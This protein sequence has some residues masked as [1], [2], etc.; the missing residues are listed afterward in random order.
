MI[1]LC[2]RDSEVI[3]PGFNISSWDVLLGTKDV[4]FNWSKLNTQRATITETSKL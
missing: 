3:S 4:K 1:L 2:G